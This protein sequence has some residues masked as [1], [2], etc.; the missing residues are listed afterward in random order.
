M[1]EGRRPSF[2]RSAGLSGEAGA[3]TVRIHGGATAQ[4]AS[5]S[6]PHAPSGRLPWCALY[7]ISQQDGGAE[8]PARLEPL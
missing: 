4:G 8:L 5:M 3:G 7:A 2:A 1:G 6:L